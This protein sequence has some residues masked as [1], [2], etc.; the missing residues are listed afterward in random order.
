M[1]V[2]R[3]EMAEWSN[4][5]AWKAGK[6]ETPSRVRI[7]FSP[8]IKMEYIESKYFSYADPEDPWYRKLIIRCIESMA[9]QPALFKLYREYQENSENWDNFWHG[10]LVKAKIM[11]SMF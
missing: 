10:C 7:P 9:G 5:L 11:K 6:G 2:I 3:G 1:L 4:A 8:P